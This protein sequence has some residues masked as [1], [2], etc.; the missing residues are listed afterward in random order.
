MERPKQGFNHAEDLEAEHDPTFPIDI[1]TLLPLLHSVYAPNPKGKNGKPA[2][3]AYSDQLRKAMEQYYQEGMTSWRSVNE[4]LKQEYGKD[5][6]FG[7]FRATKAFGLGTS[8][9]NLLS[10]QEVAQVMQEELDQDINNVVGKR[11][12]KHR[13]SLRGFLIP[14]DLVYKAMKEY[15]P[16]GVKSRRPGTKKIQR[17]PIISVGP[18][19]Q[20]SIDGHDKLS[21][22]GIGIYG[23]RDV[24]SGRL[25]LLKAM[26]S[27]RRSTD[28][29]SMFL[30][31][32]VKLGGFPLQIASDRGSE[33]G[34]VIASQ[35]AFRKT[36]SPIALEDVFPYKLLK[37]THNITIERSWRNVRENVVDQVK[38]A[39]HSA[40][41]SDMIHDGDPVHQ[42]LL[43]WLVPPVVQRLLDQF[44]V[45]FNSY[46]V[47][48]QK[49]KVNPSGASR[50]DIYFNPQRW[51][52][53]DCLQHF[54]ELSL[55]EDFQRHVQD[56]AQL[57][58]VSEQIHQICLEIAICLGHAYPPSNW[59]AAWAMFKDIEPRARDELQQLWLTD[60]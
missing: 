52:G 14:R 15:A 12:M 42:T 43:N 32:I 19:E 1:E 50:N 27:N 36:Y 38:I 3:P 57:K 39:L 8:R 16:E 7:F 28:V 58:W 46:P 18:N 30:D 44:L 60:A 24:Y 29:H 41:N 6:S 9:K 54:P 11:A 49:E 23:I 2:S 48:Y 35:I 21:S 17:F 25:L 22:Y 5:M 31:T 53:R 13:L 55:I 59:E 37:S 26:P 45:I 40:Y 51:G 10:T 33:I 20:W 34:E 4:R 47:R 56:H